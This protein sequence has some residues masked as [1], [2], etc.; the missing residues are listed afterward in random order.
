MAKR[1]A[2]N[3][4]IQRLRDLPPETEDTS[5]NENED[6]PVLHNPHKTGEGKPS[7]QM[8]KLHKNL[9]T[10]K[11]HLLSQLPSLELKSVE[12]CVTMLR[13]I[14]IEQGFLVNI[15]YR[16]TSLFTNCQ[17]AIPCHV[18]HQVTYVDLEDVSKSVRRQ[19]MVQLTTEPVSVC[20]GQA[21][22]AAAARQ[23]AA[24]DALD[25]LQLM[26]R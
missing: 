10:S 22:T 7:K 12:D 11:G 5:E 8:S 1:Q 4:M 18:C 19:S 25:Y 15:S 6:D 23:E 9:K 24:R 16:F 26:R 14:S 13:E 2:A 3:Q 21:D 17:S 20:Y